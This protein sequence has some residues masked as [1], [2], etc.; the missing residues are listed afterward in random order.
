MDHT[1]VILS[2]F[3]GGWDGKESTCY[4]GDLGSTS[5]LGRSPGEGNGYPL[6]N[7]CLENSMDR[8]TRQALVHGVAKSWTQLSNFHFHLFMLPTS[9]H[10]GSASRQHLGSPQVFSGSHSFTSPKHPPTPHLLPP[11]TPRWQRRDGRDRAQLGR[12]KRRSLGH[13]NSCYKGR[14]VTDFQV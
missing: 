7:S 1:Q 2:G 9:W 5:G 10:P 12:K 13:Q 6:Q 4:V 11:P 3:P 8:G 14:K